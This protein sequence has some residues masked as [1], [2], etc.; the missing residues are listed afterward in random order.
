MWMDDVGGRAGT[1]DGKQ[2]HAATGRADRQAHLLAPLPDH[3]QNTAPKQHPPSSNQAP[4][5]PPTP[6]AHPPTLCLLEPLLSLLDL[7]DVCQGQLKVDDVGV[8][9]GV[10]LARHVDHVGVLKAAHHLPGGRG[11]SLLLLL[12][13]QGLAG[14]QGQGARQSKGLPPGWQG[15]GRAGAPL[16]PFQAPLP[17]PGCSC[18]TCTME[19]HSRMF[20]RNWLPRPSPLLAP[21]TR[22][23][24]STNSQLVG[25]IFS[26]PEMEL[27]GGVGESKGERGLWWGCGG[28]V[29]FVAWG[30]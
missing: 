17:P 23:A 21:L 22:P 7:C 14:H 12:V 20:A 30:A 16:P 8:L 10:H 19:S 6:P 1:C 27:Q 29:G 3:T 18:R 9:H 13:R 5:H 11:G 15:R 25:M 26:L 4:P 2:H 24:M 28:G